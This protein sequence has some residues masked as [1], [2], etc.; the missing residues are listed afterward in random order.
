MIIG[1][2]PTENHPVAATW[3]KNAAR[4]GTKIIL[5]D[6]RLTS[7]S[8][9]AWRSL[10]FKSGGDIALLNGMIHA[11]I[12]NDL[13]DKEFVEERVNNFNELKERV[14]DFTPEKASEVCGISPEII[15]E[16]AIEFAK[17]KGSMILWG[18]GVSQHVH[19]TD[20][21]RCLIALSTI[22]GQIG[23]PGT[24]LHPLRGQNNV[25]GASDA[26]LIPMMLPNYQKVIDIDKRKWFESFWETELHDKPGFTVTEI[27]DKVFADESDTD[28]IRGLYI[29]GENPAMSDP[30]QRHARQA[31]S[32]LDNLVVQ[33]IFFTE[34]AWF[35]DI[36]FPAS[37]QAEKLGTYTNSN[38]Q[39]QL[40][41]P[42]LD[43]PGN[44]RQD[45]ELIVEL[46]RRCGL[47]WQY[48]S[49]S[50]VYEEMAGHMRSLDNISWDRLEKEGSV[51]YPSFGPDLPGEEVIFFS[52]FP[53]ETGKAKIVPADLLPPDELPDDKF[54][55]VLTTGRVLEHWHTGAMTRRASMLEAQ[56][57]IPVVSMHPRDAKIHGF[58][59][60]DWVC[61]KTR[62]G[63][64]KLQLKLDRDVS[65]G[66][67]FMPFCYVEAPANFLTNPQLDPYGKIPEFKFSAAQIFKSKNVAN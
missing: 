9:Y 31:L 34:T 38:R 35:A 43:M 3:M 6:P 46:A 63:E 30:D 44:A 2:N 66:M 60:G 57:P 20:N 25:Q 23:K 21:A 12:A 40:G 67:L 33:D 1:S 28:K 17:S 4:N 18:M 16:V 53:T 11:I 32:K 29:M 15:S 37:A 26:G 14:A 52:G 39:I 36:I 50:D 19:G 61:V 42:V 51:C 55:F 64:I 58:N 65:Q 59:K 10:P 47:D 45:W 56:E 49:V 41:R 27:M 8:Q 13:V 54:P 5:A 7:I 22:T 24:G 62:R 48:N